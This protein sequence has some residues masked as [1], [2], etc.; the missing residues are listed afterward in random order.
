MTPPPSDVALIPARGLPRAL[1]AGSLTLV[2]AF[3]VSSSPVPLFNRYRAQDGLTSGDMAI[4][5]VTYFAGTVGAL[6][7][8]GRLANHVGRRAMAAAAIGCL[9]AGALVLTTVDGLPPLAAGR[10]L[11]GVGCGIASSAVMAYVVDAAP[12]R[13][14]WLATVITSQSPMVG[15]TLGAL[16]SGAL[17]EYGPRPTLVVYLV[18]VAALVLCLLAIGLAPET[19]PRTP[20]ALAS[21][22]PR[23]TLPAAARP[24]VPVA[25]V[26]FVATWATGA[27]YQAFG[28]AVVQDGLGTSHAVVVALVFSAYMLPSV[29]GAP[30]GGRLTVP[31]AQRLGIGI[32]LLGMAGLLT[33]LHLQGVAGFV[34]ASVVAGIGQGMAVSASIRGIVRLA[35]PAERAPTMAAVYLMCYVGAM[36]PSLV[37]GQLSRV[38]TVEQIALGYGLLALLAAVVTWARAGREAGAGPADG[39][40]ISR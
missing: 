10:F 8:L 26:V 4:A 7:V 20:G 40:A 19:A 13:P 36:V 11:M 18:G 24:L 15:L 17:V 38:L 2:V 32:F 14:A 3:A 6:L 5:T 1:V 23:V 22:R 31:T 21:L 25:L 35:A 37:S 16:G 9:I 27:F 34:A 28:P 29:L 39:A 12:A 30:L 33:S